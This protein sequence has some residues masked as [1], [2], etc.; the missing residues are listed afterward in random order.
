MNLTLCTATLLTTLFASPLPAQFGAPP[1]SPTAADLIRAT[2]SK[3]LQS[4]LEKTLA[5]KL[6]IEKQLLTAPADQQEPL[7]VKAASLA[8]FSE[9][10]ERD[11]QQLM[12][13]DVQ[14]VPAPTPTPDPDAL[15]KTAQAHVTKLQQWRT[16]KNKAQRTAIINLRKATAENLK[17]LAGTVDPAASTAMLAGARRLSLIEPET[18]LESPSP[19]PTTQSLKGIWEHGLSPFRKGSFAPDGLGLTA[20]GTPHGTWFWLDEGQGLFVVDDTTTMWMN[21]CR[22]VDPTTIESVVVN[23]AQFKYKR[24]SAGPVILPA[25][26]PDCDV[27][28]KL[29][30]AEQSLHEQAALAWQL[31]T[32]HAVTAL[33]AIV[34]ELPEPERSEFS[35]TKAQL[36]MEKCF[37]I[38]TEPTPGLAGKWITEG[39]RLEFTAGGIVLVNGEPKGK[40]LWGKARSRD[41]FVFTLGAGDLTALGRLDG[42]SMELHVIGAET[43][44]AMKQ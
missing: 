43:K 30:A 22:I 37:Q 4:Q 29:M 9:S 7:K 27:M 14:P 1:A 38:K 18:P 19:S 31:E 44:H 35:L 10:L 6:E 40:W 15:R 2:K 11:L 12:R 34:H 13:R 33:D 39:R 8:K 26:P 20:D 32:K 36:Q 23:G 25:L 21:L 42:D 16:E 28:T 3:V 5:E 17:Q 41:N 24:K